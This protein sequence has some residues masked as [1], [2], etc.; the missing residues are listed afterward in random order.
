VYLLK[1]SIDNPS[2][3]PQTIQPHMVSAPNGLFVMLEADGFVDWVLEE[4]ATVATF[5]S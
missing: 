5:A 2:E 3:G 4:C 1:D